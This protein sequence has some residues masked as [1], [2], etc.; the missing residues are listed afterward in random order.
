MLVDIVDIM[1]G[2]LR[3]LAVRAGLGDLPAPFDADDERMLRSLPPDTQKGFVA[4]L[5]CRT[6]VPHGMTPAHVVASL[7]GCS[8]EEAEALD[9]ACAAAREANNDGEVAL[10]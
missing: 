10:L 8:V 7:R 3:S 9:E 6:G 2:S 1:R 5:V 4:V